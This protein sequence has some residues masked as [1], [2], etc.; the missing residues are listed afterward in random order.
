MRRMAAVVTFREQCILGARDWN[1]ERSNR[2]PVSLFTLQCYS[3]LGRGSFFSF[4]AWKQ[5]YQKRLPFNQLWI[6]A[7][8]ANVQTKH[9]VCKVRIIYWS[10]SHFRRNFKKQV[11]PSFI[12]KK[13]TCMVNKGS[14]FWRGPCI[15]ALHEAAF[16]LWNIKILTKAQYGQALNTKT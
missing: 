16:F 1:S 6:A 12:G 15:W 4:G 3:T 7:Q 13:S 5:Y 9:T 8:E 10:L 11:W 2:R 14:P